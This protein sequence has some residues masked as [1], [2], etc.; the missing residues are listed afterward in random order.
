MPVS[1]FIFMAFALG[2]GFGHWFGSHKPWKK[3]YWPAWLIMLVL[4]SYLIFFA[5]KI[6]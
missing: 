1:L 5:E 4:F 2:Y 6:W 3:S